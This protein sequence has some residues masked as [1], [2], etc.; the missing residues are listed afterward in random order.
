MTTE[1]WERLPLWVQSA[2]V[3]RGCGN[4]DALR[5]VEFEVGIN[6]QPRLIRVLYKPRVEVIRLDIVKG[7]P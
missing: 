1:E 2:L 3:E 4:P 7:S 6:Q 5:A